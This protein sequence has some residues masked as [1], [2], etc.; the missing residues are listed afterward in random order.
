MRQRLWWQ[1]TWMD[2]RAAQHSGAALAPS[3]P[4]WDIKCPLNVNDS[5]LY[6]GME[7]EPQ[8]RQGATEMMFC[9]LRFEM[10]KFFREVKAKWTFNGNW[11]RTNKALATMEEKG[12]LIDQLEASIEE[13]FL[14]YCDPLVPL[15][16]IS[17]IIARSALC[18][19]RTLAHHPRLRREGDAFL[20]D[21]E[22]DIRFTNSLK[23]LEYDNLAQATASTRHF[24]WHTHTYFQWPAMIVV[25]DTLQ[26]RTSGDDIDRAWRQMEDVYRHHS[27][28]SGG[29]GNAM[30]IAC[31]NMTLRAW[32]ARAA[33]H[34]HPPS[35]SST[36]TSSSLPTPDFV[37]Q[38]YTRR[39][40]L[41]RKF[42]SREY[43]DSTPNSSS[44]MTDRSSMPATVAPLPNTLQPVVSHWATSE[45]LGSIPQ[46][47]SFAQSPI[48]WNEWDNILQGFQVPDFAV[49]DKGF[50]EYS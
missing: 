43:S 22:K 44:L 14:R 45:D 32:E 11:R 8:E 40:R 3:Q 46:E 36:T 28:L 18:I 42:A 4:L 23:A 20:T 16:L 41:A 24:L 26:T 29:T 38:L 50:G 1:I 13:K 19:L 35:S 7:K 10:A 31:G 15:H 49:Q 27:E 21:E 48:D 37:T 2:A 5:D 25:L 34:P 47:F 39:D 12:K 9:L 17:T 33:A 6:P 30:Y